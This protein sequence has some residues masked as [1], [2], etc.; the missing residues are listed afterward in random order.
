MTRFR[1]IG[2][3]LVPAAALALAWA[4][5]PPH[6]N[7]PEG[8]TT[9]K[10]ASSDLPQPPAAFG[11]VKVPEDNPITPE[12]VALGRQLYYDARLSSDGSRSCYSC[13]V[14]EH[15]LTDGK[16]VA[17]GAGGKVLT[18][19]SPSL[20]NV[21]YQSEF[22]WDGRSPSMEKQAMAAWTGGNMGANAEEITAKINQIAGYRE[23]FQAVFG[24]EATP[25]HIVQAITSYERTY[26]FCGDTAYD[27][28]KG[29]DESAVSD[30]AKRGAELFV[31]KAGCGNCHSGVLFT[32]MKYHNV[33][34][35]MDS[36]TPDPGRGKVTSADAD[37]GAFKTPSLRDI[38]RSAPYFH[39][40]SVATLEE[41]VNQMAS[42]GIDNP[43][44]DRENLKDVK[45]TDAEKADVI[46]FLKSLDCSCTLEAPALP[47]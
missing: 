2:I 10:K 46:E 44:L 35:G 32:D 16:P 25:D 22:Y 38:S 40:G 27:K 45:L 8:S 20:W 41:A 4:C 43:H 15:G 37:L 13:H 9:E 26:L 14:C 18:R 29:G 23:Q 34:I 17:E 3:I 33:G 5:A 1:N 11:A 47:Q 39:N 30:A 6:G 19:S 28:W 42:G 31:A 24:G 12:K 36:A 7:A 21:A